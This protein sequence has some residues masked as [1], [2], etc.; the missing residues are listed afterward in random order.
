MCDVRSEFSGSANVCCAF[1]CG[2]QRRHAA[3]FT[4]RDAECSGDVSGDEQKLPTFA[5]L[6]MIEAVTPCQEPMIKKIIFVPKK[7]I[8]F[9]PIDP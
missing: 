6:F 7:V 5:P 8:N 4:H 2:C 3:S 9:K 1:Y